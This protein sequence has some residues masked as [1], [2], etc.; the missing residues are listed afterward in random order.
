MDIL[1]P[2]FTIAFISLVLI[3]FAGAQRRS[4]DTGDKIERYESDVLG[5]LLA[6]SAATALGAFWG[7]RSYAVGVDSF[8][9]AIDM[10]LGFSEL[11]DNGSI[12]YA[13]V[14]TV[15]QLLFPGAYEPVFLFFAFVTAGILVGSL[16]RYCPIPWFGLLIVFSMG[17]LFEG[18]NQFRQLCAMSIALY[19]LLLLGEGRGKSFVALSL[20]A[21]SVHLSAVVVFPVLFL[22]R[23]R[24]SETKAL[25]MLLVTVVAVAALP[26]VKPFLASIPVFGAYVGSSFDQEASILTL[27]NFLFRAVLLVIVSLNLKR[28]E[29]RFAWGRL[30]Y[31]IAVIGVFFQ[32]LTLGFSMFARVSSYFVLFFA[33]SIPAVISLVKD[34]RER[35]LLSSSLLLAF[36]SLLLVNSLM[37]FNTEDYRY[38]TFFGSRVI[39]LRI[40]KR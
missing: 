1:A 21:A 5:W 8:Q 20:I 30:A 10:G 35:V 25:A 37:K 14:V 19:A 36:T 38:E 12:G 4:V 23:V 28:L 11:I 24:I 39:E 18:V 31:T 27:L 3:A 2:Y 15:S 32:A 7:L 6:F 40:G 13:A 22:G 9:Y 33:L 29:K 26:T 34:F 17:Y 16:M